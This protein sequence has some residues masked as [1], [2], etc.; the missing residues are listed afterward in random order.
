M[1]NSG[2]NSGGGSGARLALAAAIAIIVVLN[3][4]LPAFFL[5]APRSSFSAMRDG[6]SSL[7]AAL[8]NFRGGGTGGNN[9]AVSAAAATPRSRQGGQ[10]GMQ[11][12]HH[13]KRQQGQ[14]QLDMQQLELEMQQEKPKPE[15]PPIPSL[16]VFY[17]IDLSAAAKINDDDDDS[18]EEEGNDDPLLEVVKEQLAT[19]RRSGRELS[20]AKRRPLAVYYSAVDGVG[21]VASKAA[22]KISPELM[23]REDYC[24]KDLDCVPLPALQQRAGYAGPVGEDATLRHL[25]SHCRR[26]V[27]AAKGGGGDSV[28]RSR[29]FR[30]AYIRNSESYRHHS[31]PLEWNDNWRRHL[32]EAAMSTDENDGG[33]GGGCLQGDGDDS[34]NSKVHCD[35]CGLS[36]HSTPFPHFPGNFFVADCEYV[37]KL[38]VPSSS[39]EDG[40]AGSYGAAYDDIVRPGLDRLV[41]SGN[42]T[43]K[44]WPPN[45]TAAMIDQPERLKWE[46]WIGS[47]PSLRPCDLSDRTSIRPWLLAENPSAA[48][49]QP[50]FML[51]SAPRYPMLDPRWQGTG[52]FDEVLR[53][54]TLRWR[55][56][57]LLPGMLYRWLATYGELPGDGSWV[58]SHYPDGKAW[59]RGVALRGKS[60]RGGGSGADDYLQALLRDV[61]EPLCEEYDTPKSLLVHLDDGEGK[62]GAGDGGSKPWVL[63][64]NVYFPNDDA[65]YRHAKAV[66]DEQLDQIVKSHAVRGR[67]GGSGLPLKVYY[68]TIG[69]EPPKEGICTGVSPDLV[70]CEHLGHHA[71]GWENNT[72]TPLH[73]YCRKNPEMT[74]M[75]IVREYVAF[76]QQFP[77]VCTASGAALM[78][79]TPSHVLF[80]FPFLPFFLVSHCTVVSPGSPAQQGQPQQLRRRAER[81][82][83]ATPDG[84][85]YEP[86][87]PRGGYGRR[88]GWK[89][90]PSPPV[91]RVRAAILA[92]LVVLLPRQLLGSELPAH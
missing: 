11:G 59:K 5:P 92:R 27:Q 13:R 14:Q 83:A 48:Q 55:D 70:A 37:S 54:A 24:G 33:G 49:E 75:Y 4:V 86:G 38:L 82:L 2:G 39:Q 22:K 78:G 29:R 53:H 6:T 19:I 58:W 61:P 50:R 7:S 62:D 9:A 76:S 77:Q 67:G 3:V 44:M 36:F 41:E 90:R 63:F 30:V 34:S 20:S 8:G 47:H 15:P 85:S 42:L 52:H 73:G 23:K 60:E 21:G 1:A 68:T 10:Q 91:R 89:K 25:H 17:H 79:A 43:A 69:K 46:T 64:Y 74:V 65:G 72:L 88:R 40:V 35:A 45:R 18:E 16:A 66:I 26:A 57:H 28:G 51:S 31:T 56:V 80:P 12:Y 87:V 32:T 84:G 81:D 71:S